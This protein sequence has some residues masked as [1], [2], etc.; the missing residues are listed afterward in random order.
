MD[1]DFVLKKGAV[2][3]YASSLF[4]VPLI[5]VVIIAELIIYKEY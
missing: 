3:L 1:I 4:L 5:A 2:Y